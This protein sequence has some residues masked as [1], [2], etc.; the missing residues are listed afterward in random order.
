MELESRDGGPEGRHET[1][2]HVAGAQG[3]PVFYHRRFAWSMHLPK[4]LWTTG[5][6]QRRAVDLKFKYYPY[7]DKVRFLA[8]IESLGLRDRVT[9][10][11]VAIGRADEQGH[12]AG[13]PLWQQPIKFNEYKCEQT[14]EVPKLAAGKYVFQLW[15]AGGEGLPEE[16]V[17]QPFVREV[18]P[19]EHNRLGISDE[20][21]AAVYPL[22]GQRQQ[23]PD[24]AGRVLARNRG[25]LEGSSQP[26]L[27][28]SGRAHA[29]ASESRR[30]R[31]RGATG[32]GRPV[33]SGREKAQRRA[34]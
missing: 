6:E 9:G 19:W 15:L 8:G 33:A 12:V 11:R 30:G 2:I 23:G 21:M 24:G 13:E 3:Q 16:P 31:G 28:T 4:Q 7:H 32:R 14:R 29:V 26:G 20:I 34:G 10:G 27:G 17:A 1:L 5:D 25:A 22:G 18:F